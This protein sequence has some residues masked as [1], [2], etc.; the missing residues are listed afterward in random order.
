MVS[1][2]ELWKDERFSEIL[3]A[4]KDST[5]PS[6]LLVRQRV[7][8]R[9]G[10]T[11]EAL[12]AT[13]KLLRPGNALDPSELV[14]AHALVLELYGARR[15][16]PLVKRAYDQAVA[17]VGEAPAVVFARGLTHH[18]LDER[19]EARD[20]ITR[21]VKEER[22]GRRTVALAQVIYVLGHFDDAVAE[23]ANV[24]E[25][26][27]AELAALRLHA[28]VRGAQG[29]WEAEVKVLEELVRRGEKSDSHVHDR[30][31][32]A[33]TL[34]TLD[35]LDAVKV[36]FE[37]LAAQTKVGHVARYARARLGFLERSEASGNRRVLK[38][39]P[40]THQKRNHCGPAVIELCARYLGLDLD[41]EG[42]ATE[43]KRES[44][45]PM[46]EITRFL[47][48][49]GI[50]HRR[51]VI[52]DPRVKAAIDLG[53]PVILQEEY[54][55]T[56]HVAVITGYD[57]RLGVFVVTD[58]MTHRSGTRPY[59]WNEKA[60][61]LF[62]CG[63]VVVI[64]KK[65][66]EGVSEL[67]AQA[68][69]AGLVDAAHLR[70]MDDAD[71]RRPHGLSGESSGSVHELI[72]AASKAIAAQ[73]DFRLAWLRRANAKLEL[74]RRSNNDDARNDFLSDLYEVRTRF[75]NDEWPLQVHARYLDCE[76]R[77]N[78]AAALY[79]DAH[80]ADPGDGNN[81]QSMG[82]MKYFGGD[83]T[84]GA[85]NLWEALENYAYPGAAESLLAGVYLRE[86]EL[87][88]GEQKT[89]SSIPWATTRFPEKPRTRIEGKTTEDLLFEAEHMCELAC[90][91]EP[92]NPTN[93]DVAGF[94]A[95][96]RRDPEAAKAPFEKVVKERARAGRGLA[97][98]LEHLGE[99]ERAEELLRDVAKQYGKHTESQTDLASFLR[100]V[101]K[102][103]LAAEHLTAV[104]DQVAA[105]EDVVWP[106]YDA[107]RIATSSEEACAR[108]RELA[109][110]RQ[111]KWALLMAIVDKLENAAWG[112][113]ATTLLRTLTTKD[114][115]DVA[116]LTRL[117][118]ILLP[119]PFTRD[120]A[121]EVL[122]RAT[123]LDEGYYWATRSYALGLVTKD[124]EAGLA[125]IEK[126][127][128]AAAN[129][130]QLG[131]ALEVKRLLL[132][133][134]DRHDDAEAT[135]KKSIGAWESNEKGLRAIAYFHLDQ[136]NDYEA[137]R[138][139]S[140]RALPI[141]DAIE[142]SRWAHS[143]YLRAHRLTGRATDVLDH[144]RD[145]WQKKPDLRADLAWDVFWTTR[146]VDR[147]LA[148]KAAAFEAER[149]ETPEAREDW[150]FKAASMEA[151]L[152]D[153]KR[154]DG[155]REKAHER[156]K[157]IAKYYWIN[158]EL[159]RFELAISA[160]HAAYAALPTDATA[161]TA[162]CEAES[163]RGDAKAARAVAEKVVVDRPY[164][165]AGFE[166]IALLAGA[167]LDAPTALEASAKALESAP[168]CSVAHQARALALFASGD[169]EL[170]KAHAKHAVRLDAPNAKREEK[171][172][173]AFLAALEGDHAAMDPYLA[174][175]A[176]ADAEHGAAYLTKLRG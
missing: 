118:R 103:A 162:M 89:T 158:H 98:A 116:L 38:A 123:T 101:D 136:T 131:Y 99:N 91:F 138:E 127:I 104:L 71:R 42:I 77:S 143:Y 164:A 149:A 47:G 86:V 21:A 137:A 140:A 65:G 37:W 84:G 50:V 124:P 82:A 43:V 122:A 167:D 155:L 59:G 115:K 85:K 173:V 53:F 26:D 111:A 171:W 92:T 58:P 22:T 110:P 134:L 61:E 68:T 10:S 112:G 67:E 73:A 63:V 34:A 70:L 30:V 80:R 146:N 44:G 97:C 141:D 125:T 55:T 56:S 148:R 119:S 39:F 66:D 14:T 19:V 102:A 4:T 159:G 130:P 95:L 94:I 172:S 129:G 152:G 29:Q 153:A 75:P 135:F 17:A 160:A 161:A 78:E 33:M 174:T 1:F 13:R 83:L 7:Q 121:M 107:L 157:Q 117:G 105:P 169:V 132:R 176:K 60:G 166:R 20:L 3:E 28:Q 69:A 145:L 54:S 25:W 2:T 128:K 154:L 108:L 90:A 12:L 133:A 147:E 168:T 15:C 49:Q 163:A 40:T 48:D 18:S 88:Q 45:T 24:P 41:P 31:S 93:W 51:V 62:G 87:R 57:D 144:A 52:D 139:I 170:A 16:A 32:L 72:D 150:D 151:L 74:Y 36:Q 96:A 46:F 64:G 165:H 11:D 113:H 79:A 81:S 156:P 6:E 126:T 109:E 35:R 106:L 23:L 9:R 114:P 8:A 27:E 5:A 120:E 142:G 76:G 175:L 100:R